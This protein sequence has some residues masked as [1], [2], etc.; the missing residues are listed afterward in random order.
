MKEIESKKY[1]FCYK[2]IV[3][4]T[5]DGT[6]CGLPHT[7]CEL[8]PKQYLTLDIYDDKTDNWDKTCGNHRVI[9]ALL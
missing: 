7:P 6:Y 1:V 4:I 9:T 5:E 8:D 3:K 2:S